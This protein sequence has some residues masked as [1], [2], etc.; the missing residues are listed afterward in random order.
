MIANWYGQVTQKMEVRTNRQMRISFSVIPDDTSIENVFSDLIDTYSDDFDAG[1]YLVIQDD[2]GNY[3]MPLFNVNTIGDIDVT[4]SYMVSIPEM[5]SVPGTNIPIYFNVTGTLVGN[6]STTLDALEVNNLSYYGTQCVPVAEVF[7]GI[8]ILKVQSDNGATYEVES[9]GDNPYGMYY[10][11]EV[12]VNTI[13]II[14][15]GMCPGVGYEVFL[16]PSFTDASQSITINYPDSS[17]DE[18]DPNYYDIIIQCGVCGD[19]N[20]DGI[21][22][23]EDYLSIAAIAGDSSGTLIDT[24]TCPCAVNFNNDEFIDIT[25]VISTLVSSMSG[26][27]E[28]CSEQCAPPIVIECGLCGDLDGDG[29]VSQDDYL[30]M[31]AIID[32][33]SD[34]IYTTFDTINCPCV[35]D[36]DNNGDVNLED[37]YLTL[38]AW[39]GSEIHDDPDHLNWQTYDCSEQCVPNDPPVL[40]FIGDQEFL[41]DETLDIELIATDP[42]GA[43]LTYSVE[44]D[45]NNIFPVLNGSTL[46]FSSTPNWFGEEYITVTVTDD[47][48][49]WPTSGTHEASEIFKVTVHA[50]NDIPVL[51][52]I[53]SQEFNEDETLVI[54]LSATDID[55]DDL[56]YSAESDGTNIIIDLDGSTLILTSTENWYGTENITVTVSDASLGGTGSETFTVTVRSVGDEPILNPIDD[57]QFNEDE[58]LE[59]S[60]LAEDVETDSWNLQYSAETD[61]T[62][63]IIDLDGSTL[64]LTSTENWFGEE[65]ITVTVTD[66]S[67]LIDSKTFKVT[68]NPLNDAPVARITIT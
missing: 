22:H 9:G 65:N 38:D 27:Y 44:S 16:G 6:I 3:F 23:F 63:I 42:E 18:I 49:G 7:A 2:A 33:L 48:S 61:G 51:G 64:T 37:L 19:V 5:T 29:S 25:D 58:S 10:V 1:A 41:E 14:G 53:G 26:V 54:Q 68:V 46:V 35:V 36:F 31:G 17:F 60:L 56:F 62:N 32:E 4:K 8:D 55:G 13:D 50:V 30:T 66:E 34:N 12:N 24:V 43:T 39:L 52:D 11:P 57:Q 47:E 15:D 20:G 28:D 21:V 67:S 59:I 45:G 40:E